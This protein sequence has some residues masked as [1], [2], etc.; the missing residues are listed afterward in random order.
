MYFF[1]LI[2]YIQS[3]K[4]SFSFYHMCE[5]SS[6]IKFQMIAK[7]QNLNASWCYILK[8]SKP[9]DK[10]YLDTGWC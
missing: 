5:C 3:Q 1:K 6:K 4:F 10:S 2:E 8:I 9:L 7:F